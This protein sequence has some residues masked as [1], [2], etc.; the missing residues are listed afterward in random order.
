VTLVI[1]FYN[2]E[3]SLIELL[4]RVKDNLEQSGIVYEVLL[5]N[6]AST[7][8]SNAVVEKFII[9]SKDKNFKLIRMHTNSGQ[10]GCFK[11]AFSEASGE[12]II[13]MDADLQD[14]PSDLYFFLEKINDNA[15]MVMGIRENRKH[16]HILKFSTALYNLLIIMLYDSPL[17]MHSGSFIAFKS[18]FVK[19]IPF[20]NND[21]RYLPLIAINRGA[22]NIREI[23]VSHNE[24]IYGSSNYSLLKKVLLGIPE[25]I[26]FLVR[27]RFGF[28]R[29]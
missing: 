16:S 9:E 28:Y 13:R 20:K 3:L 21:H 24:R 5:I 8:G 7:D 29:K 23:I 25:L 19:D 26:F 1:P 18:E 12:Y 14:N 22:N 10:T 11:K 2:E 6:D 4:P 27:L 17:T 15:D